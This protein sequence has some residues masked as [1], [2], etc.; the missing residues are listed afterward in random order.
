MNGQGKVPEHL[1]YT[2]CLHLA[3]YYASNQ[4]DLQMLMLG[5][6]IGWCKGFDAAQDIKVW[7][8]MIIDFLISSR[9][10]TK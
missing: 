8:P 3:T 7:V 1:T 9:E 2:Q 10:A 5:W 4:A 6:T